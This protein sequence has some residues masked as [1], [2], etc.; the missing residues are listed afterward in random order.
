M[1]FW[2]VLKNEMMEILF[3]SAV[4]KKNDYFIRT[5][6]SNRLGNFG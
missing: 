6:G 5:I 1:I 4:A 2:D 3:A